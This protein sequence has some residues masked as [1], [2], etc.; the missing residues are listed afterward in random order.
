M[1]TA[2]GEA[3]RVE[4]EVADHV[5]GE[6]RGVGLVVDRELARVAEH[7]AVGAQDAHARR[8]ER[9]HPHGAHD[10][11]DEVGDPLA[12]LGR[13]LVGE[14]DRQD[15]R[16]LHALVDEV[17]D[18]VREHP[19]LARSGARHDQQRSGLV[20]HRIELVGIQAGREGRRTTPAHAERPLVRVVEVELTVRV[21]VGSIGGMGDLAEEFFVSHGRSGWARRSSWRFHSTE[22]LSQARRSRPVI[23][24]GSPAKRSR[25]RRR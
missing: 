3:L 25:R 18:A 13:G 11:P 24:R 20:D 21:R 15:L 14:R 19:G 22:G 9:R 7:V 16:R 1:H 12:H 6:P 8:V 17:G 10:R 4:A 2:R 5:A 23:R